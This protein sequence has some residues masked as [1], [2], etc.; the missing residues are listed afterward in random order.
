MNLRT[1]LMGTLAAVAIVAPIAQAVNPDDRAGARGPGGI[2]AAQY[3]NGRHPDNR[4]GLRGPGALTATEVTAVGRPD[5]RADR[6]GPGAVGTAQP[7][8]HPD[9]RAGARGPGAGTTYAP[10]PTASRFDWNDA[11]I[12]G[13]A[14][15][16]A[17]LLI[18]GCCFI[19][20]SRRSTTHFA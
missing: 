3:V 11:L 8:L 17:A 18:A 12:G 4:A 1:T 2:S 10:Q 5:D 20:V 9:N 16:G 7:S 13:V 15:V 6:R 19:V 14:G